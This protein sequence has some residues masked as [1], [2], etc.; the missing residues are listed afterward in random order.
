[1]ANPEHVEIVKQGAK[2]IDQWRKQNPGVKLDL[3]EADLRD[4][5]LSEADLGDA[6]FHQGYIWQCRPNKLSN[7]FRAK[8]PA[9][10]PSYA[11]K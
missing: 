9:L 1:M 11:G 6:D 4:A 8:A 7:I 3:V 2:A 5:D 10:L